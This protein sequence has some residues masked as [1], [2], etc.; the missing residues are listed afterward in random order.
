MAVA[1]AAAVAGG[2]VA[3][4]GPQLVKYW[5]AMSNV[6]A[7]AGKALLSPYKGVLPLAK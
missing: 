2:Y 6:D 5:R 3:K 1:G 7:S 4:A